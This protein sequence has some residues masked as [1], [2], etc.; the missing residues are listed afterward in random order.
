M[1]KEIATLSETFVSACKVIDAL[2]RQ[3]EN[4][5]R[6]TSTAKSEAAGGRPQFF[7]TALELQ[8]LKLSA[9]TQHRN[10]SSVYSLKV[11]QLL[12]LIM[13]LSYRVQRPFRIECHWT[14]SKRFQCNY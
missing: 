4:L 10:K 7:F 14:T 8:G 1:P 2:S 12:S 3:I 13:S 11:S 9:F 6:H 5:N